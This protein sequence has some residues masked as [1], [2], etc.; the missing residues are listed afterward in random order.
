MAVAPAILVAASWLRLERPHEEAVHL[1]ALAGLAL[2]P[3]LLRP[4]WP[5]ALLVLLP[6]SRLAF[7]TWLHGPPRF[8]DGFLAFYDVAVPFDPR[9]HA[10]M[11]GV[12]LTAI[13]GFTLALGLAV[14]ARRPVV[15]AF[16]VVLGAGWP[17]TLTGAG[18]T[19][20]LVI[21]LVA[22][23]L[24]A[25]LTARRVPAA[26][27]PAAA[28]VVLAAVAASTS[29]AVTTQGVIAWQ[30]WDFY[31]PPAPLVRVS[32]VWN[33]QYGGIRFPAER[34]TVLEVKAP[35]R[36]LYW[37]AAVLDVFAG[38][39]WIE[40]QLPSGPPPRGPL[41]R[42]DVT[43]KALADTRLVGADVPVRFDAGGA[44]LVEKPGS[45]LLPGGLTRGFRYTVWSA[46]PQPTAAELAASRPVYPAVLVRNQL[47]VPVG[48]ARY[49]RLEQLARAVAGR[50]RTPY[51][52]TAA[53]ERW[54]RRD[55]GFT[56]TN[57]PPVSAGAPLVAF[58]AQT[59]AGYCQHFAGA[60][61]LMLRYLGIPA[62]VVVGFSS[63]TYDDKRGVWTVTD[64]DA[65]AWVEAWFRGYGWLPFDPTPA[66]GRPARGELASASPAATA[67]GPPGSDAR[68][69]H[70][71][72]EQGATLGGG[73]TAAAP[74]RGRRNVLLVLAVFA[75][76]L[77]S[78]LLLAKLAV[79]RVR[80]VAR[81]PRRVAAA[82]RRELVD[83]LLDQ[84][85]DA[86][87][88][89]TLHELG[90]L[91][92]REL[93]VDPAPFVAATTSARFG[94]PELADDAARRARRELRAL[95]RNVRAQLTARERLRGS[96][97]LRSLGLA[98]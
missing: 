86:A 92:R 53:L 25:G 37:R 11:R 39:R 43:V 75:G 2:A 63:G 96:F 72:D 83:F 4:R 30:H 40:G 42:Q 66:A 9:V 93:A 74:P 58:V 54:F 7:G 20:G 94:P 47:A 18:T 98:P 34:T 60:M 31:D 8:R 27:V 5:V 76:A 52:A 1:L 13:F 73:E 21:L 85:I 28:A 57:H 80:Y 62:R 77:G 51:A 69:A 56:Y 33:A 48:D 84:R 67:P 79:R 10:E 70:G 61:A 65:H 38:D 89:A 50:A 36:P 97:S 22:L 87:R 78:G 59:R 15:A 6:A 71:H 82:C 90:V 35:P 81:D 68:S 88:S 17:A 46:A 26:V 44:P 41:V 23:A 95:L 16:V 91:L 64:H 29:A 55:G 45:V 3:A 49:R 12:V 24:L 14:A 32:Y 19:F